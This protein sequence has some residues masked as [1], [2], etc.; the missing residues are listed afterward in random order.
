[1]NEHLRPVT[2]WRLRRAARQAEARK[3]A[4]EGLSNV[5]ISKILGV[6]EATVRRDLSSPNGELLQPSAKK[7][8]SPER[9]ISPD[10]EPRRRLN[11]I[12]GQA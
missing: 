1:M 5:S 11:Q 6:G 8:R 10:D 7:D 3:L 9:Q 2:P 4:G 12:I